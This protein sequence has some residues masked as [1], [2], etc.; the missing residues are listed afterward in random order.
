MIGGEIVM[1]NPEGRTA[2]VHRTENGLTRADF[3]TPEGKYDGCI[4]GLDGLFIMDLLG[5]DRLRYR[6]KAPERRPDPQ[7]EGLG[8]DEAFTYCEGSPFA[9]G[10][11]YNPR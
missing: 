7:Q 5:G 1:V 6:E 4:E 8:E 11:V 2:R 10:G 3:Y 9:P